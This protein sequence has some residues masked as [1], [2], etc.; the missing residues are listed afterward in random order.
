MRT[1]LR[2]ILSKAFILATICGMNSFAAIP[3]P[4]QGLVAYW[5]F[6]EGTGSTAADSSGDGYTMSLVNGPTWTNGI[7]GGAL[8][9]NGVNNYGAVPSINLGTNP[10]VS[11]SLWLKRTYTVPGSGADILYEFSANF[12]SST[13]GFMFFPDDQ[14]GG[15]AVGV[16]GNSGYN[17]KCYTQPTSGAWHHLVVIYDKSQN[18]ANEVTLYLDAVL[19]TARSQ[20]YTADNS[21]AFATNPLYLFSRGGT[22]LFASGT[23]DDLRIYNRT[24][25]ASEVT[26]LYNLGTGPPDTT[27]PTVSLTAP[28][29]GAIVSNTIPVS[30]TATDNVAVAGVQFKV[31]GSNLGS[32]VLSTPYQI[33]WNTTNVLNGLHTVSATAIDTSGNTATS[34]V[35]VAVSNAIPIPDTTPPSISLTLPLNGAILSNT[36]TISATATDNVAVAG[37]QFKVDGANVG[38]QV[39]SSPY[40]VSWNTGTVTNGLHTI[41]AT[42]TDTSGNTATASVTVAVSNTVPVQGL[43]AYWTFNEGTGSTVADS[44]GNGHTMSLVNGPTWT[45]GI[46]GGALSFNGVNNY[47]VAPSINPGAT[48]A[49][50]VSLWLNRTYTVPSGGAGANVLFEFSANFNST[51]TGFEFFPDDQCGGMAVGVHGN[52]GYNLKCYAQPTSGAWHHLVAIY[53]KSQNAANEVTL[54]LDGAVQTAELAELQRRQQQRLCHQ[55]ALPLRAR[56]HP[57]L[58]R[59]HH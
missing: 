29:D 57:A 11:M 51:S 12:N 27:P 28:L 46:I 20:A 35:T 3:G 30:A 1:L 16:H 33:S 37:V 19:Q 31:D 54:Y 49:I 52:S 15:M 9:F 36:I 18:A 56:R 2:L 58:C 44:S 7:I 34:S 47:G 48:A 32:E 45:T 41:S 53:D 59:R 26:Q 4:T 14:C 50:S 25:S 24:L 10:A 43:V 42:A 6:D 23:I 55:P 21:N 17:I 8:S 22:Q 40:Q 5:T 38:S 13:T 39:T